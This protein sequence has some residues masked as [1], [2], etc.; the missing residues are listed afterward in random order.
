MVAHPNCFGQ[1]PHQVGMHPHQDGS[2]FLGSAAVEHHKLAAVD[3]V[4]PH[5]LGVLG[6]DDLLH[7]PHHPLNIGQER[8]P[9]VL[10]HGG[11][12]AGG[13]EFL[14]EGVGVEHKV[15]H[16]VD[17]EIKLDLDV[18]VVGRLLVLLSVQLIDDLEVDL[19]DGCGVRELE[20]QVRVGTE[21]ALQDL[22]HIFVDCEKSLVKA[23]VGS[24]LLLQ[25]QEALHEGAA[26]GQEYL[27]GLLDRC[28]QVSHCFDGLVLDVDFL[29]SVGRHHLHNLG[30]ARHESP[31]VLTEVVDG[32]D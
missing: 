9:H 2:L 16:T 1:S 24:H 19:A 11:E 32:C 25:P 18:L 29:G 20:H 31:V 10:S 23:V 13:G 14:L 15:L 22:H 30:H 17:F 8:L 7:Y 4:A 5:F 12:E 28:Q 3:H 26:L 27:G 21:L 6:H